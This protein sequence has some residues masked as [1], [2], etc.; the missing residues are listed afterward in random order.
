VEIVMEVF[1]WMN[2]YSPG[3]QALMAIVGVLLTIGSIWVAVWVARITR[4]AAR[5]TEKQLASSFQPSIEMDLK[6]RHQ[7]RHIDSGTRSE[8][9]SGTIVV[10][11][12]GSQP[13][14]I[15]TVSM[16]VVYDNFTFDVQWMSE[17]A[18][19]RVVFPG[20]ST[21]YPFLTIN[22]PLGGS[23]APYEQFAQIHCSDLAGVSKRSFSISD[24]HKGQVTH[25]DGFQPI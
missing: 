23:S 2:T 10:R 4:R 13:L 25:A 14:K 8:S 15:I 17:S 19:D 24:R 11:N 12:K 7:G 9:V 6:D 20:G 21:E 5:T 22:V 1:K 16:K 3:V 18:N